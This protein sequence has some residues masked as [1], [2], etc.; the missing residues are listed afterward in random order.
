MQ[1]GGTFPPAYI[2]F[3][4]KKESVMLFKVS[5]NPDVGAVNCSYPNFHLDP[6]RGRLFC[7]VAEKSKELKDLEEMELI[8][9]ERISDGAYN[10]YLKNKSDKMRERGIAEKRRK[11]ES[12]LKTGGKEVIESRSGFP[13]SVDHGDVSPEEIKKQASAELKAMDGDYEE[14]DAMLADAEADGK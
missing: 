1:G 7:F 14:I 3:L 11:L 2:Y 12:L 4:Q 5:A 10:D 9:V 8:T 6:D 13:I